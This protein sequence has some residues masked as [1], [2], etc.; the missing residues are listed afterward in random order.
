M[1]NLFHQDLEKQLVDEQRK[2]T[3]LEQK[4]RYYELSNQKHQSS[5][6]IISNRGSDDDSDNTVSHCSD[7]SDNDDTD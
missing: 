4:L 1:L 7:E 6:E 3:A 5:K 2:S